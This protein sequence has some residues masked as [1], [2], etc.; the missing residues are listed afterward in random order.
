MANICDINSLNRPHV[1]SFVAIAMTVNTSTIISTTI[2]VIG[3][4]GEMPT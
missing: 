2:S 1:T 4:V 3:V